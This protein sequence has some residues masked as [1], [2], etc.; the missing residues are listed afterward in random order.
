MFVR[1]YTW[2]DIWS[3]FICGIRL[4]QNL[5]TILGDLYFSWIGDNIYDTC[6]DDPLLEQNASRSKEISERN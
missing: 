1:I 4:E 6:L 3:R 5:V 2:G